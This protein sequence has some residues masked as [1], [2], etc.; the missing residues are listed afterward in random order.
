M[1]LFGISLL[2]VLAMGV[3]NMILGM[4]WYGPLF[5]KKWMS[6][7]GISKAD[8]DSAKKKG[9]TKSYLF[10]FIGALIMAFVLSYFLI[11]VAAL[12]IGDA[13]MVAI[14]AWLGFVATYS[15]NS[16]LW[17]GKSW[18]LYS[19]NSGYALIALMVQASIFVYW[20]F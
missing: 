17:E 1:E 7:S 5:G 8:I 13:L 15:L 19:I 18:T 20:P 3:G 4:L 10:G 14:I 2:P 12:T 11:M 6:E 9:M 16:V